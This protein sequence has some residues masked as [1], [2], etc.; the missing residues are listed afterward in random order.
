[1]KTKVKV[2]L[3]ALV[4]ATILGATACGTASKKEKTD[5]QQGTEVAQYTCPMHPEVLADQPGDCP[6]CGMALIEKKAE[7]EDL[8]EKQE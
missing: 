7:T 5:T 4:L 8:R 1:M 3:S 6:K 2:I